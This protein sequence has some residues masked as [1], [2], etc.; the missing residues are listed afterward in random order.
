MKKIM[1]DTDDLLEQIDEVFRD[2]FGRTSLRERHEDILREAFELSRTLDIKAL[3]EETGDLLCSVLQSINENE[4]SIDELV[5][6]TLEKI[7]R[8]KL[9][10]HALG[11]KLRVAIYGGAFGPIHNGHID[12]SNIIL[13]CCGNEVDEVWLTPCY[14]HLFGKALVPPEDRLE[15]CR[16][17]AQVNARIKVFDYE[18]QN[19]FRGETYN[20]MKKLLED[21]QYKDTVNF[22]LIIGLDNA[23]TIDTWSSYEDLLKMTSFI[24]V[25]RQGIKFNAPWCLKQPHIYIDPDVPPVEISST[26]IKEELKDYYLEDKNREDSTSFLL[27][28]L[29]K[30]VLDYILKKNLFNPS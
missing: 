23:N 28:Y 11:R 24:V 22:K 3:K 15:M 25:K 19:K 1:S 6:M 17:A 2:S 16:L 18:I 27:K 7:K 5:K 13:N 30:D 12:V 8:R 26:E 9:Q 10:Y 20:F 21:P 29:N 14:E 4:W